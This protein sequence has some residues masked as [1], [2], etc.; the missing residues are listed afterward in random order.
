MDQYRQ[1][2]HQCFWDCRLSRNHSTN[3]TVRKGGKRERIKIRDT[4]TEKRMEEREIKVVGPGET[5]EL[6]S[7]QVELI[8]RR[9]SDSRTSREQ[10][11]RNRS[12]V[13]VVSGSL[14]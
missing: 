5:V 13:A 2:A 8:G 3:L 7:A 10:A 11:T 6:I 1:S 4:R 14:C 9:D 12:V